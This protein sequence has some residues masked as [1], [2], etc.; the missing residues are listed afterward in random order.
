VFYS[1]CFTGVM[2][3]ADT[4]GHIECCVLGRVAVL[5]KCFL[6]VTYINMSILI[7]I[8]LIYWLT[9]SSGG[10]IYGYVV[11]GCAEF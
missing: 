7:V 8:L 1:K 2:C 10:L 4:Q 9:S 5:L 3:G 6:H 11:G